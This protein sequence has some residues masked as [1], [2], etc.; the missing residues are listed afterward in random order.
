MKQRK[1]KE[2]EIEKKETERERGDRER[3]R[4]MERE[5]SRKTE[6]ERLGVKDRERCTRRTGE[7]SN[8]DSDLSGSAGCQGSEG[9][10]GEEAEGDQRC[11][12]LAGWEME[13]AIWPH[14][15]RPEAAR[16]AAAG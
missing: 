16:A 8:P 7:M 15:E 5:I 11:G 12:C 9:G 4:E 6:R 14:C 1:K 2:R 13:K 3:L 10:P